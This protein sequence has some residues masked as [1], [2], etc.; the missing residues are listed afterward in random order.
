[1]AVDFPN[2]FRTL[3]SFSLSFSALFY[4]IKKKICRDYLVTEFIIL[5]VKD[6]ICPGDF[7]VFGGEHIEAFRDFL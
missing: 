5:F 2:K 1:M 3:Y 6:F 7:I 4:Y